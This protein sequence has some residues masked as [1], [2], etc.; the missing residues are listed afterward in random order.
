MTIE[1]KNIE[2]S[3]RYKLMANSVIPRPIAWIV[4]EDEVVNVAP[5]SYFTPL[6]SN[7]PV[8]IVSI[9]HKSNGEPKDTLKNIRKTK[10][11]T[12]CIADDTQFE[13]LHFSS[14][15]LENSISEADEF[16]IELEKI[17]DNFPPVIKGVPIAFLC[18]FYEEI[19]L[20]GSKT[21]PIIVEIKKEFIQDDCIDK[22]LHVEFNPLARIGANYGAITEKIPAPKIP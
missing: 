14:K 7:P 21:I 18:E 15:E 22:A 9:G 16:D 13:K 11:C 12:I 3:D 5:F 6:S 8:M 20:K 17:D 4:T 10:K 1:Y 2:P 19:E